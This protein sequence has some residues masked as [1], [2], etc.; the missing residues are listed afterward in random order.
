MISIKYFLG[1]YIG[2]LDFEKEL[3]ALVVGID[4]VGTKWDSDCTA[5]R[6]FTVNGE[7]FTEWPMANA[8][9]E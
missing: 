8:R 5:V 6:P 2:H 7:I 4:L 3:V 9:G 1:T